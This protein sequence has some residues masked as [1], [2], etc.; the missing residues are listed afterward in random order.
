MLA[1]IA[2]TSGHLE[3]VSPSEAVPFRVPRGLPLLGVA[4]IV[5]GIL[6]VLPDFSSRT[7]GAPAPCR[8]PLPALTFAGERTVDAILRN[9]DIRGD[10]ALADVMLEFKRLYADIRSGRLPREEVLAHVGAVEARLKELEARHAP[11]RTAHTWRRELEKALTEKGAVL[12]KNPTA[13]DLGRAMADLKLDSASEESRSLADRLTGTAPTLKLTPEQS[14]ALADVLKNAAE[15]NERTPD[16]LS[17]DMDAAA[18]ALSLDDL[19]KFAERLE[20]LARDL[21]RLKEEMEKLGGLARVGEELEEL[22]GVVTAL[23]QDESGQWV[24]GLGTSAR[25][26]AGYLRMQGVD[27]PG[28]ED[29]EGKPGVGSTREGPG[30]GG[31]PTRI[32]VKRTPQSLTGTWGDGASV[33]EIVKGAAVEGV[34]SAPYRDVAEAAAKLAEDAVH[35]EDIPLGYRFYIKRYF[36]LIRPPR[37]PLKESP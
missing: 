37:E 28:K 34:A 24:F 3:R 25:D 15:K 20:T 30:T 29:K 33:I 36:Q 13:S 18:E 35:S 8:E 19:K 26:A 12:A 5:L 9:V 21:E 16:V 10:R 11:E 4:V 31:E 22:K 6:L 17:K 23:R 27:M 2:E 7:S 1:H 32:D 14:K